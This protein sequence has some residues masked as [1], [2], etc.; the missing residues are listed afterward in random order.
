MLAA[1]GMYTW[2]YMHRSC[3]VSAVK[4]ASAFLVSQQKT[5][6][7]QYQFTTTV[8]RDSLDVPVLML[9]EILLD[10]KEVAVPAC[11]QKAKIELIGYMD[12]V[13]HAFQASVARETDATIRDLLRESDRHYAN[14]NR[15]LEAVDKCAPFCFP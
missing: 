4:D 8:S 10:T 2:N 3:G 15:E 5:Y 1:V 14:F 6:D 12:S 7:A 11:M 13:N 9:E